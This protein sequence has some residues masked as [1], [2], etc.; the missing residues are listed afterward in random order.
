MAAKDSLSQSMDNAIKHYASLFRLP[1]YSKVVV[2][3]A[4]ICLAVGLLST[5]VFFRY[6]QGIVDGLIL[7]SSLFFITL[8]LDHV[9]SK[10]I[11]KR[12]PIYDLR[13]TGVLSLFNWALWFFFI[14]VGD[15][16]F[17][18]V[19]DPKWW[20]RICLLGFSAVMIFRMVVFNASSEAKYGH[21]IA[22]ALV[23]P[24][25][26]IIPFMILWTSTGSSIGF[27]GFLFFPLSAFVSVIASCAFLSLINQVGMRSLGV[28]S[29]AFFKAFLLTWIEN[30][31]DP[32]EEFLERLGEERDV[33][34]SLIKFDSTKTKAVLVVPS[35][36]PGPFKNIG[37]SILPSLLKNAV[38][39]EVGGVACV[40]HGLFGHELDLASQL[41]NQRIIRHTIE[42]LNFEASE[43]KASPFVTVNNDSATAC[44]QIFGDCA[45]LSMTLAPKTTEDFPQ[46]LGLFV[47]D[48][49]KKHG[50]AHCVVVNA[51]NSIDGMEVMAEALDS[52][53]E[54]AAA[55][56]E[57]A[58][59]LKR[60]T[61]EVGIA[62]ISPREFS[63]EDGMGDGG[64][65]V[66]VARVHDRKTA[67][68]VI[69]GNNMVS[70]LREQVL[71]ALR[72]SGIDAG[73]VY[74]TDTHSVNA[75][76]LGRR[77]YHPVGEAIAHDRLIERIRE[78]TLCALSS[79]ERVRSGCR[80]ITVPRAKVIG[81]ERLEALSLLTDRGLQRAKKTVAPIF[82]LTGLLLML[83][84]M[85]V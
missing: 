48:E 80:Y 24:L 59:S 75:V 51:H 50:L 77:G 56:L 79:L 6:D 72:S 19:A 74:T 68:V 30:L 17:L 66:L 41:Q 21:L 78:A 57:K 34:L 4:F 16:V 18:Y 43:A 1:Q 31:N 15:V 69:D 58:V 33:E 64:I 85:L 8:V 13:R 32:F 37:S 46:E 39:K 9:V 11:L 10:L 23:Q 84:L 28:P 40:P 35:V 55:C 5:L 62:S 27:Y 70:G 12:D 7:G 36:H 82:G 2:L 49:A 3:Q 25:L 53:K 26:C 61:F 22:A 52:L 45:F 73:E 81:R 54:V 29:L 63:L 65:T 38:E 76:V 44:C 71:T 60:F 83:F 20:L 42:G 47:R 67:H 14:G